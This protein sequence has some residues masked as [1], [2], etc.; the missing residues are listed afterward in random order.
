MDPQQQ[1]KN[2]LILRSRTRPNL[3]PE[4]M[5]DDFPETG[6][7]T[8][9]TLPGAETGRDT[10]GTGVEKVMLI[11][12]GTDGTVEITITTVQTGIHTIISGIL[13]LSVTGGEL[14]TTPESVIM[15][16]APT[17]TTTTTTADTERTQTASAGD[18]VI[19]T[20]RSL[21]AG[22]GGSRTVGNPG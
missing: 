9:R 20:V 18:M 5:K 6:R 15:I 19:T 3:V 21:T 17:I 10:T 11:V 1:L 12:I 4:A 8:D 2:A 13:S 14:C 16:G 7:E 22:G